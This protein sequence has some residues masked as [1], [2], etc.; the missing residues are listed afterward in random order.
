MELYPVDV[1][2][3]A[4]EIFRCFGKQNALL[5]VGAGDKINTMTIGWGQLGTLWNLPVCTVYVRPERYTF[6]FME[7]NDYFTVSF[8]PQDQREMLAFCGRISGREVDKIAHCGAKVVRGA[9]EAPYLQEAELVLVCKKLYVQDLDPACVTD[10]RVFA[11]Y[12]PQ[13]GGWHRC[14]VGQ[15]VEAYSR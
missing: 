3:L 8:L 7:E 15:V 12:T 5:T 14:Y 9:G 4:P 11:S 6:S 2:A 10:E 13:K 1:S